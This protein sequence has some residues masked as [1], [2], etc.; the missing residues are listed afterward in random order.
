[1]GLEI[2]RKFLVKKELW[3]K[4]EKGEGE[5]CL[6][7]YLSTEPERTIRARV[8]GDRA[9]LTI[10]GKT[11]NLTRSEFEYE[12]PKSEGES[13][14]KEFGQNPINKVRYKIKIK[15][16][17]WEVDEFFDDNAGLLV[18]E[19]ELNSESETFEK[20]EWIG[21][22]ISH[23]ARYYNVCLQENPFKNW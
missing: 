13:I 8:I 1:M 3:D 14:I 12:I 21:E 23:D 7:T 10:K 4:V 6:Q 18:A 15:D 2:E 9:Y 16:H 5:V 22:E 19:I 11:N 20:P 17:I